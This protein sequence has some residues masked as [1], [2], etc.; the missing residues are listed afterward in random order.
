MVSEKSTS[1]Y[2]K[3]RNINKI[4]H[5]IRAEKAISRVEI[6][7]K[8][9]L[10]QTSVGRSVAELMENGYV[11][12]GGNIGN[13]VGRQ[14]I[15]LHVI[16]QK[17][18]AIGIYLQKDRIDAGIVDI[19]G[20]VINCNVYTLSDTSPVHV[21]E[22]IKIAIDTELKQIPDEKL[23]NLVGIGV[24]V[25]GTVNYKTGVVL[26]SPTFGWRSL[27]LGSF[28][29]SCYPYH[30][31]VDNDV[32]AFAKAQ[33]FLNT[34][35]DPNN[36]L[37]VHLGTGISLGEMENG[38]LSRG[39]NNIAGEVGHIILDP[40]G[41][42]CDCGRRGCLQTRIGKAAIE[43][44]LGVSFT[45]AV[46]RYHEN[47]MESFQVMNRVADEIAMWVANFVNIF[48]PNELILTGSM[49]DEWEELYELIVSGC[50]R[51]LWEQL[52]AGIRIKR[53]EIRAEANNIVSSASNVFYKFVIK[54]G[55]SCYDY[56]L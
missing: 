39:I 30:I 56:S 29:K 16:P 48:D 45:E 6:A 49:L 8:M 34:V 24:S 4:F 11:M 1:Q 33:R 14:R 31:I 52:P 26:Q 38:K 51:F 44:E 46:R 43:R 20:N 32:K 7:K 42:L 15:L 35:E 47:D 17:V 10:S 37:V 27:N 23:S 22:S 55:Q 54:N 41:A 5:I 18:M 28:L 40:N 25:P 36:F 53:P 50:K 19:S 9:K 2:I 3:E 12:E 21:V 13:R